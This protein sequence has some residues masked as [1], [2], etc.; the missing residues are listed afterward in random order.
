MWFD[1]ETFDEDVFDVRIDVETPLVPSISGPPSYRSSSPTSS[2][3]LDLWMTDKATIKRK[4][5]YFSALTSITK[6]ANITIHKKTSWLP[7]SLKDNIT[8]LIGIHRSSET[9]FF[10]ADFKP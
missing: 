9:A 5:H 2:S 7:A 1:V 3:S 8:L 10:R 4:C 6:Y